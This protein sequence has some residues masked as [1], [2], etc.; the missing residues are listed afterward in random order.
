MTWIEQSHLYPKSVMR[1]LVRLVLRNTVG[2]VLYNLFMKCSVD[3]L[4]G[5]I[6]IGSEPGM[7][8]TFTIQLQ[9]N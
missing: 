5:T 1:I 7:G 3:R 9:R 8:S 6:T 4:E 2:D